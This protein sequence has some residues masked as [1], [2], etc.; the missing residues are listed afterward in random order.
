MIRLQESREPYPRCHGTPPG[1]PTKP[2][3]I[4]ALEVSTTRAVREPILGEVSGA[5]ACKGFDKA[6]LKKIGARSAAVCRLP[7]ERWPHVNI[8][9][10][11][12]GVRGRLRPV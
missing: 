1:C 11:A 9:A 10:S 5:E 6:E 2:A 7:L 4:T 3:L 8:N 12:R